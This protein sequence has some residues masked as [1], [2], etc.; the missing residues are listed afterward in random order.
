MISVIG[1]RA[2]TQRKNVNGSQ[3]AKM[4]I[5][6]VLAAA[7]A[8]GA[9]R[10]GTD[11]EPEAVRARRKACM[12][13]MQIHVV[14]LRA[15]MAAQWQCLSKAVQDLVSAGQEYSEQHPGSRRGVQAALVVA[16]LLSAVAMKR[17]G[18]TL[19][20]STEAAEVY[21]SSLTQLQAAAAVAASTVKNLTG[22]YK[23][24]EWLQGSL[25]RLKVLA[26]Q[27]VDATKAAGASAMDAAAPMLQ[28]VSESASGI[29]KKVGSHVAAGSGVL[30]CIT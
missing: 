20:G 1:I 23:V 11:R 15:S 30:P 19:P 18:R 13:T 12:K 3:R 2:L 4:L 9:M 27:G 8:E 5:P 17:S 28:E 24:P 21:E 14:K 22:E 29:A 25:E 26:G 6:A 16:I 10:V 7:Y